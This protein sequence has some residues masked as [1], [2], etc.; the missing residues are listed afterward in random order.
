[1]DVLFFIQIYCDKTILSLNTICGHKIT[2]PTYIFHLQ[3]DYKEFD[4]SFNWETLVKME[5]NPEWNQEGRKERREKKADER[6]EKRKNFLQ[7]NYK[8]A[9]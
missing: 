9:L 3:R 2:K 7:L 8:H 6:R 5:I 1:M 4:S